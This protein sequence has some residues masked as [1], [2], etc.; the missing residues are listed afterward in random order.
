M[1]SECREAGSSQKRACSVLGI[2]ERTF[3]R[4]TL[5]P[6][7]EDLRRGPTTVPANALT[8]SERERIV[9]IS[10]SKEFRDKSP[11]QIV[12]ALADRGEFVASEAS[13]YRVLKANDLLAHRGR[14]KPRNIGRPRAYEATK[15][16]QL[17]SWDITYLKS[18]IQGRYF[19]LH[20]F[21]DIW[22]VRRDV[23]VSTLSHGGNTWLTKL[24]KLAIIVN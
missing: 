22:R 3:Q 7:Q 2:S 14:S 23:T 9:E 20:M 13:F 15:T 4:W 6:G 24:N 11:H 18:D 1:I 12:P 17:F 8:D 5:I 10:S 16:R 21:L 19:F